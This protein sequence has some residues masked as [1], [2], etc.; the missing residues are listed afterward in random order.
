MLLLKQILGVPSMTI[1]CLL[2]R[3]IY[4]IIFFFKKNKGTRDKPICPL[5]ELYK[6]YIDDV[7]C[8]KLV[9]S[10]ISAK[11]PNLY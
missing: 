5:L 11:Q 1:P 7:T 4:S 9:H 3:K 2:L 10:F 8:L 6:F